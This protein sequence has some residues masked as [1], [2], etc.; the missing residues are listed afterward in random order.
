MRSGIYGIRINKQLQVGYSSNIQ[1]RKG[2]HRRALERNE[3]WN[4]KLQASYNKYKEFDFF[5]IEE[6]KDWLSEKEQM[7]IEKLD[8][9]W[10]NGYNLSKG[11]DGGDTWAMRS[12]AK[13]QEHR[14]RVRQSFTGKNN[15]RYRHDIHNDID[16][17]VSM[18]V[19]EKMTCGEIAKEY[20]TDRYLISKLLKANGVNVLPSTTGRIPWNKGKK[21]I[22]VIGR[23]D[24]KTEDLIADR[25]A[26]MSFLKI[27]KKY[28][29]SKNTVRMRLKM[30]QER[31]MTKP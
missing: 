22:G 1:H 30:H 5:I 8:T 21:T 11:G 24:V 12:E 10:P 26:G 29:C 17:I 16:K 23:P 19:K 25:E 27:G 7:Y 3:H 13:K 2:R 31:S 15:P 4:P 20:N 14:E 28:N 9:M 18:Y 6:T